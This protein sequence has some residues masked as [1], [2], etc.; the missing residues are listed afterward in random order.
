MLKKIL[1]SI[2]LAMAIIFTSF[3]SFAY[4]TVL[5]ILKSKDVKT[6]DEFLVNIIRPEGDETTS[7]KSYVICGNA[8]NNAEDIRVHIFI[9]NSDGELVEFKNTDGES[10]WDIGA[11]G[12]FMKE[13]VFPGEGINSIRIAAYKKSE[14]SKLKAGENL[15]IND[16]KITVLPEGF[17]S[18]IRNGINVL[19]YLKSFVG[20]N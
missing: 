12:I 3:S 1:F 13:V 11:S 17:W 10:S 14:L 2:V 4:T 19:K 7:K 20:A 8:L 5:D 15:Q 6:T 16:F 18:S 9:E